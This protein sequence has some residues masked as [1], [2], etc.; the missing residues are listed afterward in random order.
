[1]ST[2]FV[3]DKDHVSM[4]HFRFKHLLAVKSVSGTA[5]ESLLES[6]VEHQTIIRRQGHIAYTT[7]PFDGA[8]ILKLST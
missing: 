3:G 8:V 2:A 7:C 1:M 4:S 5:F 6:C